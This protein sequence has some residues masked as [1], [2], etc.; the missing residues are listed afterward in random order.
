M[1][2]DI[3]KEV[4]RNKY[5]YS[6]D[7]KIKIYVIESVSG[8]GPLGPRLIIRYHL[9]GTEKGFKAS[10]NRISSVN[11]SEVRESILNKVFNI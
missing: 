2:E 8:T 10:G 6:M 4:I 5:E 11:K 3:I 1:Y 7:T 9:D